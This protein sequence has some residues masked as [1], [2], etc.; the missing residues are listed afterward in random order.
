METETVYGYKIIT[1]KEPVEKKDLLSP[2]KLVKNTTKDYWQK[3]K[4]ND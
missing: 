2:R 3:R 1:N 4:S